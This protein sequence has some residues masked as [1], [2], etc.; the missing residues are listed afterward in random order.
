MLC[1]FRSSVLGALLA[2]L[3]AAAAAAGFATYQPVTVEAPVVRAPARH[4]TV[5]FLREHGFAGGPP[6]S[7][8]LLPPPQ[9]PPPWSQVVL[10]LDTR[11]KGVQYDRIGAIRLDGRYE[12]LRFST[13]EPTRHGIRYRVERDVSDYAPLLRV[14][15]RLDVQVENV[16]NKEYNGVIYLTGR[17]VYYESARGF[18]RATPAARILPVPNGAHPQA[19]VGTGR[20]ATASFAGLPRN[21]VRARLDVF[22]TNH[23]CDEF[24]YTNVPDAY[25][26]AHRKDQLCGGGP[27]RELDVWVDG[28]LANVIYP[29][30]YIWTGGVNPLLWRPLSAIHTLVVPPYQVDL[31]AWAGQLSDGKRH[32]FAITVYNDRG[33]WP[34]DA[35]LLLWTD[36]ARARTGGRVTFDDIAATPADASVTHLGATGGTYRTSAT[37]HWR[38]SGYV[39]TSTGRVLHSLESWLR[40][41]NVQTLDLPSGLQNATQETA[42]VTTTTSGLAG[43]L[44][45]ERVVTSYPLVANALYPPPDR[46]KPYTLV[47]EALVRAGLQRSG[48]GFSC[49][50]TVDAQATLK[51]A[52]A[53]VD[54]VSKGRTVEVNRCTGSAGNFVYRKSARDGALR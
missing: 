13:A 14:P 15:R 46:I 37:R 31:D 47:I 24:W 4:C 2:M 11:I 17:L 21:L 42:F 49:G 6:A 25:A 19:W 53:H 16:V 43:H 12:F 18:P 41:R 52:R 28:R 26:A 36:P 44:R 1:G 48:P 35:N 7:A 33:R 39:D 3:P 45:R 40:F 5:T 38:V 50:W 51:R 9:C 32:A 20:A 23:G 22:A 8:A 54:A 29:F 10:E 34:L 27:Y 30:P